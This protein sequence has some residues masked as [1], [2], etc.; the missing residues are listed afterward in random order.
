MN[1]DSGATFVLPRN[2]SVP[3]YQQIQDSI[4]AEIKSGRWS[5][6]RKIPSEHTLVAD[7]GV[8][9]MT[10]HRALRELTRDGYLERV[11]GLGTFVSEPPGVASLIEL[12]NIADEI[13]ALG[14]T[15]T[16][17]IHKLRAVKAGKDLCARME[18]SR[19]TLVFHVLLVHSQDG[20]P[21][22]IEDRYVNSA[23]VPDF[24]A[25]DFSRSTPS[26]YLIGLFQPDEMEHVVQAIMPDTSMCKMLAIEACEP[27]LRMQRRTWK[28][29]TVVTLA[30]FI[31]PGSRYDLAARY[32]AGDVRDANRH[33]LHPEALK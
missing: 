11:H 32:H 2:T 23:L 7:L 6:G 22:Q 15:H 27:C 1:S 9:R 14:K 26:E 5:P 30:T 3:L 25:V 18:L 13:R 20:I 8:S 21:I 31:Y 10:I 12:R 33:R 16:A 4:R 24:M 19:G 28:N 17:T 29:S